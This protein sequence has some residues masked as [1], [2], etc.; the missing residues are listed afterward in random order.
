M[1]AIFSDI[2][3]N[4]EALEAILKDIRRKRIK[5][6]NV[7]FLGDAVSYGLNS[8]ECLTLLEKSGVNVCLGNH[9]QRMLNYD[10]RS[11]RWSP[12]GRLHQQ[13][14]L[15]SL[16]NQNINFIKKMPVFHKIIHKGIRIMMCH[17]E[18]NGDGQV[19]DDNDFVLFEGTLQ[20]MFDKHN[21]QIVFFGHNHVEKILYNEGGRSYVSVGSS[22]C[23]KGDSTYYRIFDFKND[24]FYM[25]KI[26]VKFNR[27]KFEQKWECETNEIKKMFPKDFGLTKKEVH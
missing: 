11:I 16:N 9:E 26:K 14:T 21:C 17:Y 23:V 2:H 8:S 20:K 7:F 10:P 25:P 6:E 27:K 18:F 4:L 19:A 13:A 24:N 15:F 12:E 5:P 1:L 22:G 3:G